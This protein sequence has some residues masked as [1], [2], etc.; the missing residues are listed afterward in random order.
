MN[1]WNRYILINRLIMGFLA[2]AI[3]LDTFKSSLSIPEGI[4]RNLLLLAIGLYLGFS[5]CHYET[6]RANKK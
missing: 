6:R 2:L 3:I 1:K 5:L 4:A